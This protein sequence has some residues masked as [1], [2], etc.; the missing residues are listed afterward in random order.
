MYWSQ[1]QPVLE[2]TYRLL[3]ES[4]SVSPD[5]V[6]AELDG[7][8]GDDVRRALAQL[9]REGFIGGLTVEQQAWPYSIY[10]TEKGM[11][12][13]GER[14]RES[15]THETEVEAFV[16]I[17]H[18]RIASAATSEEERGRLRRIRDAVSDAGIGLI[19]EV[20]GKF[21]AEAARGRR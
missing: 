9:Y 21:S 19:G 17:L 4:D 3:S 11:E 18:E 20:L 6:V 7:S 8:A 15:G 10:G 12:Q 13:A 5:Q 2:T 1:V 16:R 14:R